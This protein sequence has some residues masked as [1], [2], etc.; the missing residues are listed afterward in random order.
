MWNRGLLL[1]FVLTLVLAACDSQ[2]SIEAT[3]DALST[4]G[5][6]CPGDHLSETP[7]T[8]TSGEWGS[9]AALDKGIEY[10]V[11][12]GWTVTFCA[13]GG[14]DSNTI[15]VTGPDTGTL[16]TPPNQGGNIP[17]LSHW[18]VTGITE[19]GGS[20]TTTSV[21]GGTTIA[22]GETPETT[23]GP[24]ET[25]TTA[26]PDQTTTTAAPDDTTTTA[27]AE[28]TTTAGAETTT[29][30]PDDTTTTADP[31]TTTTVVAGG[32]TTTAA[33]VS[34]GESGTSGGEGDGDDEL[35]RTG[36]GDLG[37]LELAGVTLLGIALLVAGGGLVA[38]TRRR[39]D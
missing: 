22:G 13:K 33:P 11:N 5:G 21:A 26:G 12:D 17:D 18:S 6:T 38:F 23:A 28:T 25:T 7:G 9:A 39:A 31:G 19:T 3:P 14:N 34:G 36:P 1:V 4:P 16:S 29:A 2:V 32:N 15:T 8:S 30:A 24:E 35:V 10:T 27:G 37:P 20:T